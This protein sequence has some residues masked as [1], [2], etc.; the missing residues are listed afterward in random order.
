MRTRVYLV[1][2]VVASALLLAVLWWALVGPAQ[3]QAGGGCV[4]TYVVKYGDTLY[5]IARRFGTTVPTLVRLNG[6][7]NPNLIHVGQIL[8]LPGQPTTAPTPPPPQ[9]A[10]SQIAQPQIV[11]EATYVFTPT[12]EEKA[13]PLARAG[14]VGKR[15]VYPLA[16]IEAFETVT[17]TD[18]LITEVM[19]DDDPTVLWVTRLE[20][21]GYTLVSVGEGEPLAA[22][23]ISDTQVVQP[24][25]ASPG[26]SALPPTESI[27]VVGDHGFTTEELTLWLESAEGVRYPFPI[28]RIAH[29]DNLEQVEEYFWSEENSYL[30]LLRPASYQEDGYRA[31]MVLSEEGFGP[32]GGR[33]RRRCGSWRG[34]RGFY[35][36]LHSWYGC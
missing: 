13:W 15:V 25:V 20:A 24:F 16:G 4:N 27:D 32:P 21:P 14:R 9:V 5:S 17:T 29:A 31:L 1:V 23:R 3:A 10:L 33:W 22:L 35:R 19:D 34:G 2:I 8:C 7:R 26:T 28:T 12:A 6:I 11:I 30:A 18:D 36:W